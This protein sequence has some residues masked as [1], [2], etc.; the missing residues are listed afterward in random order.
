VLHP[1]HLLLP[2]GRT[3]SVRPTADS[4]IATRHSESM[5]TLFCTLVV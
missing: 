2:T 1:T 5:L 3:G 4:R